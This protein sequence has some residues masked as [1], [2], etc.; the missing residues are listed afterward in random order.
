ADELFPGYKPGL[1]ADGPSFTLHGM[2]PEQY[3]KLG[4]RV[5]FNARTGQ[6][7][8]LTREDVGDRMA[9]KGID[10]QLDY[11]GSLKLADG[12]TVEVATAFSMYAEHLADYDL[13][14]VV[15][16]TGAP[17]DLLERLI[18]DIATIRPVSFQVGE[19]VNHYFHA[20]LHNRAVYL[21]AMLTGS[22]GVP[23]GGVSA[24][25]GNYKGGVFQAAK[26]F[27]P[28][29]GGYVNEDPFN[30]LLSDTARYSGT[31]SRHKLEGEETSYWGNGD[32]PLIVDTPSDGRKI[33]TGHTHMP[34]P[35]KLLWYT[36]AN[37]IN[38]AKWAYHL[39]HN[40]NPMIDMIIDE[41][42][43]WT[44][45]AEFADVILPAN[46]WME[47]QTLEMCASA[48]NP[49]VQIWK[50]GIEPLYDSRDD[51]LIVGGIAAALSDLTGDRR[52]RDNFKFIL[53]GRPEVYL[54]RVLA[55]SFTTEGYTVADL[56]S[57][58]Y[59]QP[60][61]ALMQYRTYP[62]IPFLEQVRD[63]LPF[64][65][66][67]GRMNSYV[68]IPEAIEY[69]ENLI[70]H[71]EAVEATPYLPNVIVSSSPFLRP[72]DYGIPLSS[73]DAGQRQVR[74][75]M[76]PWAEVKQTTNPLYEQGF[77]FHCLTPKS[78]HSVHSSWAVTDWNWIWNS[79]FGD[80][81]RADKR[82]PGVG[83]VQFHMNPSDA[84]LLGLANGDY[85]W[86]DA[87]PADRPYPGFKEDD[88]FAPVARLMARVTFNPSYPPGVTMVKHAYNMATPRTVRGA[89]TRPD[90]RALSVTGY[91][92][93]F[94]HGSQQSITRSWT[95]PMHQTDTL[96]HKKAGAMAFVFGFDV[97]NHAINTCPKEVMVRITRAEA[98]GPN[99]RGAWAGGTTGMSPNEEDVR[100]QEYM[101]GGYIKVGGKS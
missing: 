60:G 42:I 85:V 61:G 29:V 11:R 4:D 13:D 26:W 92:A 2:T 56:M 28:G 30:P 15:D 91:Q 63:S 64:Y 50:G 83:D 65:T 10:P 79:N 31:T 53:E 51:A 17:R 76:M 47:A 44:G 8:A 82:L 52:F 98:G 93:S 78:R 58:R 74:N 97:D 70:V 3:A 75:V 40:V 7:E 19:G 37:L 21:V 88:P 6:P 95:P 101:S 33:F 86:V 25:A 36:N 87:N 57:G 81:Y 94:R 49:F 62:R 18:E 16:I 54:D 41:Q 77:A 45:S 96:F 71:R 100:M 72:K 84:V 27:G 22:I 39:V 68:D 12:T 20:T 90:G 48:S 80:P 38:Q 66:D 5:V 46:S 23:G 43:E 69:G 89:E 67:T 32:R 9:E 34:S 24:W 1:A 14:T 99:G 59:G 73:I 55:G 35:T